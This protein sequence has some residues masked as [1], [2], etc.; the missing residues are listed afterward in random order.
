MSDVIT[1]E[2]LLLVPMTMQFLEVSL[3]QDRMAATDILGA[4]VPTLWLEEQWLMELRLGQLQADPA[5]QPWLLRAVVHKAT[6]DMIG[7]IGF[8]GYPGADYLQAYAPNAAEMGYSI[9]PDYRRQGYAREAAAA[10]IQWAATTQDVQQF[11]FSIRPDN[12]PSQRIA[13][14]FGFRKVGQWEDEEDGTEDV[15]RLDLSTAAD[16]VDA[17]R[18]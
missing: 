3:A 2:R 11:V 4:T 9:L 5:L 6:N 15:Y 13:A 8:H 1:T 14:H 12:L 7:H 17:A 18:T 10:L 16:D